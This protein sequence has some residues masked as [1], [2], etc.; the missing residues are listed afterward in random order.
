MEAMLK[1]CEDARRIDRDYAEIAAAYA[2]ALCLKAEMTQGRGKSA[3]SVLAEARKALAQALAR[4]G[5]SPSLLERLAR[6][7]QVAVKLGLA[8]EAAIAVAEQALAKANGYGAPDPSRLNLTAKLAILRAEGMV[9]RGQDPAP[10]LQSG[11]EALQAALRMNPRQAESIALTGRIHA[12]KALAAREP[13]R[14]RAEARTAKALFE[15]AIAR[16]RFL[17]PE[18]N[19]PLVEASRLASR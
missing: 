18:W 6:V 7:E 17:G 5:S 9:K 3:L 19:Q 15:K 8:A 13:E 12:L 14:R 11:A 1:A 2:D 16:N 10:I 4:D